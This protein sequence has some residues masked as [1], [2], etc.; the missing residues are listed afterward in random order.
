VRPRDRDLALQLATGLDSFDRE[1][2]PLPGIIESANR[3][4]F[5]EQLLESVHRVRFVEVL[6]GRPLSDRR[7]DPDDE[8]FDPL[9]AAILHQRRGNIEEAF[10]LAFLFVHFGKNPHG[11]WRY[12]REVYGRLGENGRWDWLRTSASPAAFRKWL[13]AYQDDFKRRGV[14]GGFGNHRKYESLDARSPTGTGAIIESYVKWVNPPRTHAELIEQARQNADGDPKR[15]FGDLYRSMDTVVRFGRTARF[16][17]L[18]MLGKLGVAE[19]QPPSAY[20]QQATGPLRG[21]KLLFGSDESAV[22][23]DQWL[24]VLDSYLNIGMQVLED[25]LCNWQKSPAKFEPFRG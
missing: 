6:R 16:D 17:Y 7:A 15:A 10:W 2:R 11:G 12:A 22:I 4:V 24:V 8:V 13:G 21:A 9:K 5:L 14:P 18:T 25:A 19:I 23:L 20:L 3:T 1:Q